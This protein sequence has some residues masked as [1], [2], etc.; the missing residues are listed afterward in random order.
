MAV[1]AYTRDAV[2]SRTPNNITGPLGNTSTSTS[3]QAMNMNSSNSGMELTTGRAPSMSSSKSSAQLGG[4]SGA[5]QAQLRSMWQKVL[6]ECHRSDPDR[7]GHVRR[8]SF[9]AAL[10]SSNLNNVSERFFFKFIYH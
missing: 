7:S 6:K 2:A 10:E 1:T 4:S 5:P 3:D 8:N 9:I